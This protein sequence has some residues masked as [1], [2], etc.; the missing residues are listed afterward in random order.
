MSRYRQ[1]AAVAAT[2]LIALMLP[3]PARAAE[4]VAV[5][6]TESVGGPNV[7]VGDVA[8]AS[9]RAGTTA[10]FY[11]SA[12]GTSGVKCT[13][14]GFTATVTD[15]PAAPGTATE[16][17]TAQTFGGCTSNVFGTT[18]VRSVTVNNLPYTTT[19][20]SDGVVTIKGADGAPV[21]STIVLG[22]LLGTVTCVY[23][24]DGNTLSGTASN[25]TVSIGFAAQKFTRV[26]GSSLCFSAGYFTATYS[27][28]RDTSQADSPI[29]YVN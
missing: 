10:N 21:K 13:Q 12:T 16:S 9:L 7:A 8:S 11:S 22:T 17:L 18:S 15:N 25:D 27:P 6:T 26:S 20:T 5:L 24:A 1:F 19:V 4:D 3:S 2:A 23:E 29:I 14:S 28:V